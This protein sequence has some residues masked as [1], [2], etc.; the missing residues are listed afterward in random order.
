MPVDSF[1]SQVPAPA[2]PTDASPPLSLKVPKVEVAKALPHPAPNSGKHLLCEQITQSSSISARGR[3][4]SPL[5]TTQQLP[6]HLAEKAKGRQG[7]PH[8]PASHCPTPWSWPLA[9]MTVQR[10]REMTRLGKGRNDLSSRCRVGTGEQG[11]D[12]NFPRLEKM[13]ASACWGPRLCPEGR[14]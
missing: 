10:F 8:L 4:A 1:P 12:R 5:A 3:G 9:H 13:L 7:G 14:C 11:G 6:G 2:T